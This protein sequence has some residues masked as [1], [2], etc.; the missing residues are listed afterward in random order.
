[1]SPRV[2][3]V[4][5]LFNHRSWVADAVL[6][7]VRQTYRLERVWV[8]NDGSTDGSEA[9]VFALMDVE[10]IHETI[11]GL[12]VVHSE[13]EGVPVSLVNLPSPTGPANARNVGI[14]LGWPQADLFALLDSDDLYMPTKVEKSVREWLRGPAEIGVIYSDFTTV[15]SAGGRCRQYKQPYSR[16]E[17][18]RQCIIN[19]DSL[20][21]RAALEYAGGGFPAHLRVCEDMAL[22]LKLSNRFVAVHLAESLVDIRIGDHSSTARVAQDRWREDYRRA[23]EWAGFTIK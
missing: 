1:M 4:V 19:C 8:V 3:G 9:S 12:W 11:N 16:D 17:L 13:V 21:S 5:P 6:S 18:L 23:F 2:V 22:W 20:V 7:L 10:P 15:N 14:R